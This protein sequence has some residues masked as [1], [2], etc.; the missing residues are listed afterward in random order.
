VA[1]RFKVGDKFENEE[2]KCEDVEMSQFENEG[3]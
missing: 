2:G 3:I 1:E